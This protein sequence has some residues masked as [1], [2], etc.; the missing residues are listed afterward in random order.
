MDVIELDIDAVDG[1]GQGVASCEGKTYF[2][3]D[4]LPGERV[5]AVIERDKGTHAFGRIHRVVRAS[6]ARVTPRCPYFGVCGGCL[7]QHIEPRA[8]VAF[9]QKV[10]EESFARVAGLR[11]AQVLAP[12]YGPEWNYRFRARLS[13]R[14]VPTRGG[15]LLGFHERKSSYVAD[16]HVC[17]VMPRVV[18][19]LLT[20]LHD[21]IARLSIPDRIP[22]IQVAVGD[23]HTV[24][25]VLRHLLPLTP[26]DSR[27]MQ[28]FSDVFDVQWWLQ[29][30]GL[31]TATPLHEGTA[32]QGCDSAVDR[33]S[34]RVHAPL[35]YSLP[36]FG[37]EMGF[38]P[39]DFIQANL[40]ANRTLV[41]RAVS[42]MQLTPNDR[43]LDLFCGV[44]NFT[45]PIA[46]TAREVVGVEGSEALLKKARQSATDHG[47]ESHVSLHCADLFQVDCRWLEEQ[48]EFDAI[49]LDP[50]REGARAIAEALATRG[51]RN[52]PRRIV[53][54]SC[55]P[56]TLARD[57]AILVH[58][59]EY[60]LVS[61]G[62]VNMF[63][64]TLHV[65]SISVFE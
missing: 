59:G 52:G 64:H 55:N 23:D 38:R 39:T 51:R 40:T 19:R 37:L 47:L 1:R 61:A 36:E 25:L 35:T 26:A 21:L 46:A 16:I 24:A 49:L 11:P 44:G 20:P 54:V 53:Y 29:A 4:A 48:G 27:L 22:H 42:L 12:V 31:E 7:L 18:S 30:G 56:A 10:L 5:A 65:E 63:P 32:N 28:E 13:V 60:R 15:V 57:T 34:R 58:K 3:S 17:H 9:K 43:V 6:A 14:Y 2:I 41:S 50:P 62:V 45:L 33:G 8:Q